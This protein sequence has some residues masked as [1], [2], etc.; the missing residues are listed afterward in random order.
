MAVTLVATPTPTAGS[1]FDLHWGHD[2]SSSWQ[3]TVHASLEPTD[4]TIKGRTIGLRRWLSPEPNSDLHT[5]AEV[6]A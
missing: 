1:L 6:L 5:V 2:I 4:N 3:N